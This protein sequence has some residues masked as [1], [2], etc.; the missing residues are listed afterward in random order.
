MGRRLA[1]SRTSKKS[2]WMVGSPPEIWTTSGSAS[3]RDDAVEHAFDLVEGLEFGAVGAGLRVADGAGEIAGVVDFEEREAGVLL[4]VGA[5]AAVV[6]AAVFD[7]G[8]VAVGHLGG[9]DEDF[10][11]AAVVVDVVGDEDAL[12][13]VLRA[14]L[15]HETLSSSKTILA[16]MRR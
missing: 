5:E 9:L 10:A 2:G 14:A 3:L 6:G 1:A 11:A 16:S 4:V 13:A 12:E 15:E 7:G 8:V